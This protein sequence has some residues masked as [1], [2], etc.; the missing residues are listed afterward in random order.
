MKKR[1]DLVIFVLKWVNPGHG[2]VKRRSVQLLAVDLRPYDLPREFSHAIVGVYVPPS[3]VVAWA[4]STLPSQAE[5]CSNT[6]HLQCKYSSI[7]CEQ[8]AFN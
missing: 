1:R 4:S 5:V 8:C 2:K 7:H 3:A 6:L